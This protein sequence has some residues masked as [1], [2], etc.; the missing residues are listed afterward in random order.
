MDNR[1]KLR[2]G[3]RYFKGNKEELVVNGIYDKDN[4]RYWNKVSGNWVGKKIYDFD[5]WFWG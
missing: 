5:N 1:K 4:K 2:E 3:V